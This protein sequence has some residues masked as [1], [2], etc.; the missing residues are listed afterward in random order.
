VQFLEIHPEVEIDFWGDKFP[1]M[2]NIPRLIN[3]GFEANQVYKR[4]IRDRCYWFAVVPLGGEED[5]D[6]LFFN[7]CKS[8]IKYI[9]FGSL[10]IPGIYSDTPVYSNV[11]QD[12]E[13]GILV[14]NQGDNW[15][16]T[17]EALYHSREL[18]Q[19]IRTN[20]YND[21]VRNHGLEQS[22]I[23]LSSLVA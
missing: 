10:G 23:A 22:A 20:A 18:R 12:G 8:C 13:T 21:C 14:K 2:H 9:D 4:K 17:M 3:N 6:T 7:S 15:L 1:E 19:E 5:P 16:K 11:I